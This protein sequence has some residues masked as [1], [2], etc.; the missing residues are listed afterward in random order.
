V[1]MRAL[2]FSACGRDHTGGTPAD[3]YRVVFSLAEL[4]P[5]FLVLVAD[6]LGCA[7]QG[8]RPALP[9]PMLESVTVVQSPK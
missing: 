8:N 1:I 6:T 3:G 7:S 9:V 2:S 4:D 5:S